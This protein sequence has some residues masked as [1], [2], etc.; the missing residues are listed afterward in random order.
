M[1]PTE[2]NLRA[3]VKGMC[4]NISAE[5]KFVLKTESY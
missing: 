2:S 1:N 4:K 3:E 5:G